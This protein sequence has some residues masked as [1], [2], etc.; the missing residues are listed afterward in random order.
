MISTESAPAPAPEP[1]PSSVY[2]PPSNINSSGYAPISP[3]SPSQAYAM[4]SPQSS[5]S[6][7]SPASY[8]SRKYS[9]SRNSQPY[10]HLSQISDDTLQEDL[11]SPQESGGNSTYYSQRG[12][13]PW[14]RNSRD[15][16][17][18]LPPIFGRRHSNE[19]NDDRYYIDEEGKERVLLSRSGSSIAL[20]GQN[21]GQVRH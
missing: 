11:G 3:I 17:T 8:N 15:Q 16:I 9:G 2:T 20:H 21:K 4:P 5:T 14:H 6:L 18:E 13:E 19:M 12:L 10:S 1:E 7:V